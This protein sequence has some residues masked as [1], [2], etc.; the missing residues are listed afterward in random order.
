MNEYSLAEKVLRNG[1]D[2]L[3][4]QKG[5]GGKQAKE[6]ASFKGEKNGKN[7]A[8][9]IVHKSRFLF[10]VCDPYGV[11]KEGEEHIRITSARKGASPPIHG[12][13][14]VRNPCSHPGQYE[15]EFRATTSKL[16]FSAQLFDPDMRVP[17]T[18]LKPAKDRL[19]LL[20]N[21]R[22]FRLYI[23]ISVFYSLKEV[24]E[25]A[26]PWLPSIPSIC[27]LS[28]HP[29]FMM[30]HDSSHEEWAITERND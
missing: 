29:R 11:L 30:N 13:V 20:K 16:E 19:A 2:N 3:E 24:D 9:M 22:V 7:R 10:G 1:L 17:D 5:V 8:R 18:M 27:E 21:L 15:Y 12:D 6:V 28:L 14:L 25:F 23:D 4:V 26:A